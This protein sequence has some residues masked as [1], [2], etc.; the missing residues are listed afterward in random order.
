MHRR[1]EKCMKGFGGKILIILKQILKKQNE[2]FRPD[3]SG[4]E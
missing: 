2:S 3:S 1:E 4:S